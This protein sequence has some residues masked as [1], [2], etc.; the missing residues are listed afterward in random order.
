MIKKKKLDIFNLFYSGAAVVILIGVIAKLLEWPMQDLLITGGLAIEAVV[1]GVSAFKYIDVENELKNVETIPD[2]I[3]PNV[4]DNLEHTSLSSNK[5][6]SKYHLKDIQYS[7]TSW[8]LL[9]QMNVLSI[10][11]EM[12]F[13]PDWINLKS[14][15]YLRL[16]ELFMTL[17]E[18]K[19]P[20]KETLPFLINFPVKI[21]VNSIDNLELSKSHVIQNS[22]FEIVFKSFSL[23]NPDHFFNKFIAEQANDGITLRVKKDFEIQYF[24]V[25][26]DQTK[27]YI[28]KFHNTNLILSPNLDFLSDNIELKGDTLIEYLIE[29]I[30]LNNIDAVI[31]LS[32]IIKSKSDYFKEKLWVKANNISYDLNNNNNYSLLKEFVSSM[33]TVN[34]K[35][36]R[37]ILIAEKI[38]LVLK[39]DNR[40]Y[41]NEVVNY[42]NEIVLFGQ[43]DEYKIKLVELFPS[44]ELDKLKY[45]QSLIDRL[46][47]DNVGDVNSLNI[48]LNLSKQD[49]SEDLLR[50]LN[51][52]LSKNNKSATGAQLSFVLLCK[53]Y[54]N[55]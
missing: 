33:L 42:S 17:F 15:E 38:E 19:L 28:K 23:I 16:T 2:S 43:D 53:V 9:E 6:S 52:H 1:F 50:K 3:N 39:G 13:Q 49:S 14:N 21:P 24:D 45:L 51:R 7:E 34:D 11:K 10:T 44:D 41:I 29:N 47:V 40:F 48:L 46:V 22:D 12:Y 18:K 30:D 54:N 26:S 5:P 36:L 32:Q 37:S 27:A 8:G 55:S 31:S 35:I 25:T 4:Q 20:T